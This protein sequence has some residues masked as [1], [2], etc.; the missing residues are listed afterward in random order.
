M[1]YFLTLLIHF[2]QAHSWDQLIKAQN[3][4][5]L[6]QAERSLHAVELFENNCRIEKDRDWFPVNCFYVF[7]Q[8]LE[9]PTLSAKAQTL[10]VFLNKKCL[11][12]SDQLQSI[13]KVDDL[14][15]KFQISPSCRKALQQRRLDIQY[16]MGL[17]P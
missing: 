5:Q 11:E 2:Y 14:L 15:L 16:K 12:H 9:Q 6:A 8:L 7:S 4:G 1:L 13:R 17:S 10:A 3:M